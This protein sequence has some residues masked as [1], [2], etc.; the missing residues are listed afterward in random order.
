MYFL[1]QYDYYDFC[2]GANS[3]IPSYNASVVNIFKATNL[4]IKRFWNKIIFLRCKNALAYYNAGVGAVSSKVV[5]LAPGLASCILKSQ[6]ANFG[7]KKYVQHLAP[8]HHPHRRHGRQNRRS[9]AQHQRPGID[10]TKLH[11]GQKLFRM[12]FHPQILYKF[13]PQNLKSTITGTT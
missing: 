8:D 5:G 10:F 3:A 1:K 4:R 12:T 6:N 13:L 7:A 11:F 9:R 2:S